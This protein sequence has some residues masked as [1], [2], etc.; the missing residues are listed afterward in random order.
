MK[1]TFRALLFAVLLFAVAACASQPGV[2]YESVTPAGF[3][4][5][6]AIPAP[7]GEVIL[8]VTGEISAKNSGDSLLLDMQTLEKFG[9][10]KY[11]VT[12]PWLKSNFTYTGILLKD[13]AKMVGASPAATLFHIVALDD[14]AVDITFAEAEKWPILLAT[15]ANGAYMAVSE[16]GPT[17][18]IFPFDDFPEIDKVI[19]QD[20][21]IWN[22]KTIEVR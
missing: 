22:I 8:T 6:S 7:A 4:P 2:I 3:K 1:N 14:Y 13:F 19:Y 11:D 10:V 9:L 21:W 15:Q 12:D 18:I 20:L 16:N 5:G 17:R